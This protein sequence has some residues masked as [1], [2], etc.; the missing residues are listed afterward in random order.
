MSVGRVSLSG[1]AVAMALICSVHAADQ[2]ARATGSISGRVQNKTAG[3]YL[4]HARIKVAETKTEV[5]TNDYGD[6]RITGLPLGQV[7][8]TAS[9]AGLLPQSVTLTLSSAEVTV[10][11]DFFLEDISAARPELKGKTVLLDTFVVASARETNAAAIAVNEQRVAA[12]IKNV[13]S[14]DSLGEIAQNN[15][16]E[17]MKFI[18]GVDIVYSSMNPDGISVRG[19]PSAYTQISTDGMAE[20]G[21]GMTRGVTLRAISIA[22]VQRIEVTKVPTPDRSAASLGGSVNL[23]P[24]NAF[25]RKRPEFDFSTYLNMNSHWADF[26]KTVGKD[27]GKDDAR[28]FKP[29][30]DWDF[31][32]VAPLS[33]RFG[34]SVGAS[35]NTQFTQIQRV[36][37]GYNTGNTPAGPSTAANPY[38]NLYRFQSSTF[39]DHRYGL[40]LKADWKV[41]P[42]DTLSASFSGGILDANNDQ[43]TWQVSSGN[44]PLAWGPTFIHGAVGTGAVSY[45]NTPILA[46][47]S[48]QSW[49]LNYHHIGE[50]WDWDAA[51]GYNKS[52]DT[53]RNVDEGFFPSSSYTVSNLRVDMDGQSKYLP[54]KITAFNTAGQSVDPFSYEQA[55]IGLGSQTVRSDAFGSSKE[56]AADLKRKFT[57]RLFD[58]GI[59]VGVSS[60]I[61]SKSNDAQR[62]TPVYVGPD[63]VAGSGDEKYANLPGGPASVLNASYTSLP[64]PRGFAGIQ[65]VSSTALYDLYKTKP[66]FFQY[67]ATSL[68]A[69]T[70]ASLTDPQEISERVDATYAM[71]D[72]WVLNRRLRIVTGVRYERTSDEGRGVLQDNSAQYERD[73]VT[74]KI[75]LT[76]GN[77]PIPLTTDPLATDALIY[78]RLG[79]HYEKTYGDYYPSLNTTFLVTENLL[80][81]LGWAKT[82]GRPNYSNIVPNTTISEVTT[83]A[84][85]AVGNARGTIAAKNPALKPWTGHNYDLMLE[86]YTKS[87]GTLTAGVYRKDIANFYGTQRF[88][89]TAEYLESIGLP[90][91]YVDFQVTY[92]INLPDPIRIT[93]YELGLDQSLKF[94]PGV[95]RH[96]SVFANVSALRIKGEQTEANLRGFNPLSANWGVRFKRNPFSANV[97]FNFLGHRR[98]QLYGPIA[99]WGADKASALYQNSRLRIDASVD[100]Q[101]T[102]RFL[103][104]VA[105]RNIFN[106]RSQQYAYQDGSPDYVKFNNEEEYGVLFQIGLKG[107]F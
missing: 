49:R 84:D 3:L 12:S 72:T 103:L 62:W 46:K 36:V 25:E 64:G 39:F 32:Y 44:A 17:F 14:T 59:K 90:A 81:R 88:N 51:A 29:G 35:Q 41:S 100:Y 38:T 2:P 85:D 58:G 7:T 93:G 69:D 23:I 57:S 50:N 5:L 68:R 83:H 21:V 47:I 75:R 30:T 6:Y 45:N 82:L 101:V 65:Y 27:G 73:P 80:F 96:F 70:R 55:N 43:H 16:G 54:G 40:A 60:R 15:I 61:E 4:N 91:D 42:R 19:L 37:K 106:D 33:K 31:N 67:P 74:K 107:R 52:Q 26:R 8:L 94:L 87:G 86:Y 71:V 89:A 20:T 28:T 76:A 77:Q 104:F 22:N 18:P 95:A 98:L 92:P 79:S 56:V 9:Y 1:I 24:R 97:K 10:E 53:R 99:N 48:N 78:K 11:R 105:G 34:I 102:N 13:L 63:G 66:A